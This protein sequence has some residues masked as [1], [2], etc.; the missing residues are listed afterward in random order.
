MKL[1]YIIDCNP[2]RT[3]TDC[4]HTCSLCLHTSCALPAHILTVT[5]RPMGSHLHVE[6]N[7]LLLF[8]SQMLRVD[9][10][11]LDANNVGPSCC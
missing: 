1:Y 7:S 5:L 6:Q 11:T 10:M 8:T 2:S 4:R 3:H 9:T